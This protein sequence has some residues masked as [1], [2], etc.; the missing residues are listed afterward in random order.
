[1]KYPKR[2]SIRSAYQNI[3][4]TTF[5]TEKKEWETFKEQCQKLKVTTC[6]VIRQLTGD[7]TRAQRHTENENTKTGQRWVWHKESMTLYNPIYLKEGNRDIRETLLETT[8]K[9]TK[10]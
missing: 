4:R 10:Q 8:K 2:G 1:M 6:L 9:Q 5:R 3:H 7:W